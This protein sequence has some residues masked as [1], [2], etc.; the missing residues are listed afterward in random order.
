[1]LWSDRKNTVEWLSITALLTATPPTVVSITCFL[2]ACM[3]GI[4]FR[5]LVYDR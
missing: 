3:L 2:S 5:I 4:L 1:M